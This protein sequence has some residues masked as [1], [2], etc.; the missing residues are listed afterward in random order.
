[1]T[2]LYDLFRSEDKDNY[3]HITYES[4]KQ[5]IASLELK[6]DDNEIIKLLSTLDVTGDGLIL[7]D[8]YI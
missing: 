2:G 8:D 1:M 7:W 3:G 5:I 6:L 4:M